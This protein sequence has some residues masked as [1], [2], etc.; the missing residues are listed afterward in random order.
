MKN[1]FGVG[2]GDCLPDSNTKKYINNIISNSKANVKNIINATITNRMKLVSGM[3]I[4]EE[5]EGRILNILNTARDDA[6]GF[7]TKSLGEENQLKNMVTAGSKGNF[8]NISQIMACV[9]QQNVSSGSKI[10][11]KLFLSNSTFGKSVFKCE[12]SYPVHNMI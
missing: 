7:A 4:R 10:N 9:G 5:F 12:F 8:I 3:S 11:L 2:I 1:G 6:G